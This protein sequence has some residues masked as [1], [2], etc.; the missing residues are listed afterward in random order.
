MKLLVI[1]FLIL[2]VAS[3]CLAGSCPDIQESANGAIQSRNNRVSQ[4]HNTTMPDPEEQREGL[5]ECLKSI[6]ALGEPFTLGIS[7]PGIDEVISGMC[8]AVDSFISQK[9]NEVQNQVLNEVN[10]IGGGN[11]L[12]VYGTGSDH[13]FQLK[14]KIK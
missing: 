6:Q 9:I 4:T 13:I 2:G 10:N 11:L 1:L 8:G 12:K 14:G 5:S 7:L 3:P